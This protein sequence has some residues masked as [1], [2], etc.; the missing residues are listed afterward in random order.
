MQI[1]L[2]PAT[3]RVRID[4][5]VWGRGARLVASLVVV[6]AAY[7]GA[8]WYGNVAPFE[9]G[10]NDPF[11]QESVLRALPFDAPLPYSISLISAG[12]G[13]QL[14]YHIAW[15]SPLSG[16]A[17][18]QQVLDHLAGSPKW[19]LTENKPLAGDFT[20]T[21]ARLSADG[22][23]THFAALSV[24]TAPG[25]GTTVSFDFTPIP[26]SLAPR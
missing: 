17:V 14:P 19:Q 16:D 5:G 25:G 2:Q 18:G 11:S 1:A 12:R 4:A 26:S 8:S 9:G 10:R 24:R 15:S 22:Q 3:S 6:A 7:A 13:G 20:T 21:L 23:M